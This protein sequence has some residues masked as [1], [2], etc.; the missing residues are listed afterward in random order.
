MTVRRLH[1]DPRSGLTA[2]KINRGAG[3]W[4]KT[5]RVRLY[6][7]RAGDIGWSKTSDDLY[8]LENR[9][10][11]CQR[12]SG[13]RHTLKRLEAGTF[14]A[15]SEM[16]LCVPMGGVEYLVMNHAGDRCLA[17]WLDQTQ[18]GYVIVDLRTMTQLP[19]GLYRPAASLAPP[20]FSPDD[21]LVVSCNRLKS[22]WWTDAIDDYWDSPSPGGHRKIAT[23]SV[24]KLAPNAISHHDVMVEL[25]PGWIPDRPQ[26][27]EWD[28]IW[29]PEFISERAFKIWLPDDATEVLHLPLPARIEIKKPLGT[30][31]KWLA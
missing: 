7:E 28:M 29:G 3:L 4:D 12:G 11:P 19:G 6:L 8:L 15:V 18:W 31:R 24:H 20:D 14:R 9:F 13:V 26:E 21:A 23:I 27:A 2:M 17:T 1:H 5:G 16:E 25:P 22:G 30:K 10:G